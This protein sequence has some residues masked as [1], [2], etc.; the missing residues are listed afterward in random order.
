[1]MQQKPPNLV[2]F[3]L[4]VALGSLFASFLWSAPAPEDDS[5]PDGTIAAEAVKATDEEAAKHL[6]TSS[7]NLKQIALAFHNFHSTLN[8]WPHDI[9][10]KDGKALLSW[11]VVILPYIEQDKLYTKFKMD[12]PWDSENNKKLLEDMP[13]MYASPRV[14]VKKKGYTVYQGFAG[15][16]TLFEPGKKLRITDVTDGTSNTIMVVE[17]STAVPW[18]KPAD[19]PFDTKKDLPN[20]G[21][22]YGNKPLTALCDGSVR[23]LNLQTIK[24]ETFKAAITIAGGEVLE[25]DWSEAGR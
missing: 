13:E 5:L 6:D 4:M 10:D 14:V 24:P 18:S 2:G 20:I 16:G 25:A 21:K 9:C 7:N 3:T 19:L 22:A 11:R 8:K 12:E 1:M 17:S 15:E 23:I